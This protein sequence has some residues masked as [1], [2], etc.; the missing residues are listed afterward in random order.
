MTKQITQADPG[1]H[2]AETQFYRQ[3]LNDLIDV[4]ADLARQLHAQAMAQAAQQA[5]AR[6][7]RLVTDA[8][9]APPPGPDTLIEIAAAFDQVAR[10]V[11]R[12]VMLEQSLDQPVQPAR[13]P[14]QHR[15]VP[16]RYARWGLPSEA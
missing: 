15:T 3:A 5:K 10:A 1:P 4:G 6:P 13:D 9:P 2:A 12:C 16:R 14:A 8:P 7:L 11:R